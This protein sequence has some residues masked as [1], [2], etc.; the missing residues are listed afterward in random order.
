MII[1]PAMAQK[2]LGGSDQVSSKL[3]MLRCRKGMTHKMDIASYHR[4][5]FDY[6]KSG[7]NT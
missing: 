7:K 2:E 3:H 5:K 1:C 4:V 6:P